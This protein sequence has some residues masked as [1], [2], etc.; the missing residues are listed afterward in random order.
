M[1]SSN[2]N[3]GSQLGVKPPP[4]TGTPMIGNQLNGNSGWSGFNGLAPKG[5]PGQGQIGMQGGGTMGNVSGPPPNPIAPSNNSA[6]LAAM[7]AQKYGASSGM[8]AAP[9]LGMASPPAPDPNMATTMP[10]IP[11]N[12]NPWLG[13]NGP[14]NIPIGSPTT[15]QGMNEQ[16][17]PNYAGVPYQRQ[18]NPGMSGGQFGI[19]PSNPGDII[20]QLMMRKQY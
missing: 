3:S 19:A 4:T 17:P 13:A 11:S 5:L 15:G 2:S 7:L 12:Q 14:I 16:K 20:R 9:A 18:I 1:G 10:V 6:I 8:G